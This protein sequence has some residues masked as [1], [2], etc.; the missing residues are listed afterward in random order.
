MKFGINIIG[1]VL[2][3][4]KLKL[5]ISIFIGLLIKIGLKKSNSMLGVNIAAENIIRIA[6][7]IN[8]VFMLL[9]YAL[10]P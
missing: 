3:I 10:N 4:A 8:K 9:K 6:K 2:V 7:K 1:K 5:P